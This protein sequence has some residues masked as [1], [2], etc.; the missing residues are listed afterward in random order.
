MSGA[1]ALAFVRQRH[2]LDGGDLDRIARQQAFAAG[3][4]QRLQGGGALSDATRLNQLVRIVSRYVVLDRDW[5]LD[6]AVAQ[7]RRFTGEDLVFRTIPTGRLDLQTPGGRDR[8]GDRPGRGAGVRRV[9]PRPVGPGRAAGRRPVGDHRAGRQPAARRGPDRDAQAVRRPPRPDA[10]SPTPPG[11]S[12][13]TGSPASTDRRVAQT[14]HR[15]RHLP[16]PAGPHPAVHPR[17]PARDHRL[18]R[19]RPGRVPAQPRRHRPGEL[20]VDAGAAERRRAAGRRPARAGGRQ[21]ARRGGPARRGAGAPRAQPGAGRRR[22]RVRHR[23][24]GD[25]GRVR[26]VRAALRGRAGGGP[27]PAAGR[28]RPAG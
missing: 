8:R 15:D 16:A 17:R 18:P 20:P 14:D 22:G 25:D 1:G 11:S 26:P 10:T 3:L 24:A 2:G 13:P 5:D 27:D 9:G 4:A 7:L 12:P 23:P 28:R 19:R 21:R 6:Q